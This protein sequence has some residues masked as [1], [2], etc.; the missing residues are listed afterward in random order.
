MVWK[1]KKKKRDPKQKYSNNRIEEN[2]VKFDSALEKFCYDQ[3]KKH[4]VVF[5]FQS[6]LLLQATFKNLEGTT[7][8][9]MQWFADFLINT[10][11]CIYYVDAK[12]HVTEEYKMKKKIAERKLT[13]RG[14]PYKILELTGDV[15]RPKTLMHIKKF[16]R[17]IKSIQDGTEEDA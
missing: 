3:F 13:K 10:P 16:A 2:G 17:Q 1:S 7:I 6:S 9:K 14:K 4:E 5:E 8:R 15:S 11:K 12:G